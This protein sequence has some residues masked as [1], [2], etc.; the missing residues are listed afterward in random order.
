MGTSAVLD[1]NTESDVPQT[2]QPGR[3]NGMPETTHPHAELSETGLAHTGSTPPARPTSIGQPSIGPTSTGQQQVGTPSSTRPQGDRAVESRTPRSAAVDSHVPSA[4]TGLDTPLLERDTRPSDPALLWP[5]WVQAVT[6]EVTHA[7]GHNTDQSQDAGPAGL[8]ERPK[9]GELNA[10]VTQPA[11]LLRWPE[12]PDSDLLAHV[13]SAMREIRRHGTE[14]DKNPTVTA[15]DAHH[16]YAQ[17]RHTRNTDPEWTH[18]SVPRNV[19]SLA[20]EVALVE[21]QVRNGH[22]RPLIPGLRGGAPS[23]SRP[24][25]LSASA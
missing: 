11:A 22:D 8:H 20:Y 2:T 21:A 19:P 6:G 1:G 5:G 16:A 23:T 17:W 24:T 18:R 15:Q 3:H 4:P 12:E 9:S 25:D 7:G 14:P 13:Q 10:G